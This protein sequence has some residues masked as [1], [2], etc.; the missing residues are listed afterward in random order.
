MPITPVST[1]KRRPVLVGGPENEAP[2]AGFETT[3]ALVGKSEAWLQAIRLAGA[4]AATNEN[5]LITGETGTGKRLVAEEIHRLSA[6]ARQPFVTLICPA[7]PET[8]FEAELFGYEKGAF[9]DARDTRRGHLESADQGTVFLDEVGDL[10]LPMQAKLLGVCE[11]KVYYRVGGR[12]L[13]SSN[14]RFLS[15]TNRDLKALVATGQFRRD[16]YHRLNFVRIH[17]PSLRERSEDI[18]LLVVHYLRI[19]SAEYGESIELR[20]EAE[21]AFLRRQRWSGNVRELFGVLRR[22]VLIGEGGPVAESHLHAAME[23]EELGEPCTCEILTLE[24]SERCLVERAMRSA[25]NDANLA[26]NMLG[27]HRSTLYRK[28]KASRGGGEGVH[29]APL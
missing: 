28:L 22:A 25:K 27:I 19:L 14:V 5:V 9:T 2:Q 17:L 23:A 11:Q 26:A 15:A 13:L 4:G 21:V 24:Q 1:T 20:G 7:I 29:L 8:L 16:L 6:R 18:P 3:Q 10:S 12:S